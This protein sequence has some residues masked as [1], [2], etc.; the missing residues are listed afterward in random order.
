MESITSTSTT[1]T[2]AL[3]LHDALPIFGLGPQV[4]GVLLRFRLELCDFFFSLGPLGTGFPIR[5][6]AHILG[7]FIGFGAQRAAFS[8]GSSPQF[9]DFLLCCGARSEERRVGKEVRCGV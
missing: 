8:F 5:S 6:G 3:S 4:I 2:S 7:V 9:R 1:E